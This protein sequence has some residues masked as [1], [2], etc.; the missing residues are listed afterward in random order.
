MRKSQPER[1]ECEISGLVVMVA[2]TAFF[3]WSPSADCLRKFCFGD[4]KNIDHLLALNRTTYVW[5]FFICTPAEPSALGS[6]VT[7]WPWQLTLA[8]V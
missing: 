5:P 4:Q 8:M 6:L 1:S 2:A 3:E 7:G